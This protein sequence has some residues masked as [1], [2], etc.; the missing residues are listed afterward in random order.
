[1]RAAM[2]WAECTIW[3]PGAPRVIS[4]L[5]AVPDASVAA[6]RAVSSKTAC[7][8]APATVPSVHFHTHHQQNSG[9]R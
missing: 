5:D 9:L 3:I 8:N 2:K 4:V 6:P 1:M 7:A